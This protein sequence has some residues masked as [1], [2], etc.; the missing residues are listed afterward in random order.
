M[1]TK[2]NEVEIGGRLLKVKMPLNKLILIL[3]GIGLITWLALSLTLSVNLGWL[4]CSTKPAT[5]HTEVINI[6]E[7]KK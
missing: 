7:V 3:I 5:I 1:N 4:S 6:N 2:K